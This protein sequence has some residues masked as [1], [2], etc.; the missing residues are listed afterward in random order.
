[1]HAL[2]NILNPKSMKIWDG[3]VIGLVGFNHADTKTAIR[4]S[5]N[6]QQAD[7][8]LLN[9]RRAMRGTFDQPGSF[10]M[11]ENALKPLLSHPCYNF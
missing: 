1:M 8:W 4:R 5:T 10:S 7:L 11:V 3:T 6:L 9:V 2:M